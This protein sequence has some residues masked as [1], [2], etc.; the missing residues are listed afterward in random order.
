MR[1]TACGETDERTA[2]IVHLG[3]AA[4][5]IAMTA[6]HLLSVVRHWGRR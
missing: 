3:V 1:P 6:W 4:M 5:Y 2:A